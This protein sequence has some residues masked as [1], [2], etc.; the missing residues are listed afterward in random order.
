MTNHCEIRSR[1]DSGY[2]LVEMLTVAAIIL[3]L[4]TIPV[5]LLRRSREKTYEIEAIRSLNMM[6]LAYENYYVQYDRMYPNYRSDGMLTEF[7]QYQSAEQI[8]DDLLAYGL[9][10]RRYSGY[11]HDRRNLLARGYIF[12]IYPSDYG[13]VPG[14]TPRHTYALGMI[15]YEGSPARRALAVIQGPRFFRNHPTPVPRKQGGTG[16]YSTTI[17]SMAD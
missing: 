3:I 1:R 12:S 8:W 16:L 7:V 2:T 5:A 14:M 13:Q 10:P 11:P 6:T 9:V 17:Y 15:P 4:A